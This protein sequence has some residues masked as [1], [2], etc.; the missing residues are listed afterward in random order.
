MHVRVVGTAL[1]FSI[2]VLPGGEEVA[3]AVGVIEMVALVTVSS[4]AVVEGSIVLTT[5]ELVAADAVVALTEDAGATLVDKL[6]DN[7]ELTGTAEA[8]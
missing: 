7:V 3:F 2:T 6:P 5:V 8:E 1:E 4:V